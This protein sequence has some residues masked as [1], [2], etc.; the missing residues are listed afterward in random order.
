MSEANH[1]IQIGQRIHC[2]LYGGKNGTVVRIHGEQ[3][4]GSV[5]NIFGNVGVAGGRAEME[6]VYDNG[7]RTVVPESLLRGSVQWKIYPEVVGPDQVEAAITRAANCEIQR[8][9]E[10]AE[11]ARLFEED[12]ARMIAENPHLK[13]GQ[14]NVAA[15]IRAE[16]KRTWPGVKFSVRTS[17]S[18]SIQIGWE[19]GPTQHE[20]DA[21]AGKFSNGRFDGMT[22]CYEHRRSPW[23]A[24]FGGT[25]YVLASREISDNLLE[26]ALDYV[27]RRL[28][29]NLKGVDRPDIN[30]LRSGAAAYVQI[31]HLELSLSEAV[32]AVARAWNAK[33]DEIKAGPHY[34]KASFLLEPET[35]DFETDPP[36][37]SSPGMGMRG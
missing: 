9:A 22:D 4:P 2:A 34:N 31:P 21:V 35:H 8:K 3:D 11:S 19:D 28:D 14:Q 24:A 16:L 18:S 20:V 13:P 25:N 23:T 12:K 15:N 30:S 7:T 5:R 36:A 37:G 27:Y 1:M 10:A 32:H 6:I 26:R 29:A 17:R 33:T